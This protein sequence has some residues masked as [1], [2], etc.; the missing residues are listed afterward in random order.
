MQNGAL[1]SLAWIIIGLGLGLLFVRGAM[2]IG[3]GSRGSTGRHTPS[4]FSEQLMP[5]ALSAVALVAALFIILSNS[6]SGEIQKWAYGVVG[7]VLGYWLKG[8]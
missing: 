6:S 4:A 2:K 5:V 1:E 7:I 8:S 3:R